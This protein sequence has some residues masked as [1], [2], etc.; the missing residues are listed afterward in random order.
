MNRL[1]YLAFTNQFISS[2]M[3]DLIFFELM[4]LK[5]RM[6]K[7]LNFRKMPLQDSL[8]ITKATKL[9][10]SQRYFKILASHIYSIE[11]FEKIFASKFHHLP[12][13]DSAPASQTQ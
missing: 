7:A 1:K 11:I 8:K 13:L 5:Y 10:N 2:I 12:E 9:I 3:K 4:N 6:Q